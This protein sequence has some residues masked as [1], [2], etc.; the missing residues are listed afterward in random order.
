MDMQVDTS[1]IDQVVNDILQLGVDI[2]GSIPKGL[3]AA[4]SKIQLKAKE[5][6]PVYRG[7]L[8]ESIGLRIEATQ[9][10]IEP[11][12]EYGKYL[13]YARGAGGVNV[14]ALMEWA[15]SKGLPPWAVIMSIKKHG[16]RNPNHPFM[17]PALQQE[18]GNA[19]AELIKVI[20]EDAVNIFN[21]KGK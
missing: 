16:T 13:E 4:G 14:G 9:A 10:I 2:S 20:I 5:L 6:A 7:Q 3:Q 17:L 21:N 19:A 11:A 8:K 1:Q 12:V 18:G 15:K